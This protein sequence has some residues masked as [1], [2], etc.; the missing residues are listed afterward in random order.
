M[1]MACCIYQRKSHSLKISTS[2][3]SAQ[4]GYRV[5]IIYRSYKADCFVFPYHEYKTVHLS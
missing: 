5:W 3:R 2:Q 1:N 4:D